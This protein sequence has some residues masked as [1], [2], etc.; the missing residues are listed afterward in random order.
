M[1]FA[2]RN[3]NR[4]LVVGGSNLK[5]V[6]LELG[7]KSPLIVL[8]DA[9]LEKAVE[10]GDLSHEGILEAITQ[11]GTISFDG[12][13]GDYVYGE[14]DDRVP[15]TEST[16]FKVDPS[17]PTGLSAVE[18]AQGIEADFAKDCEVSAE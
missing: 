17:N 2:L 14:A 13:S 7:G 3:F 8:D 9:E 11:L 18:G 16:I 12:L 4:N 1:N 10:L 5:R 6:T 15:P